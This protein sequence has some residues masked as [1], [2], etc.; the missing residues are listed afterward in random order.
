M[1]VE[2]VYTKYSAESKNKKTDLIDNSS[3]AL[4]TKIKECVL[5][6]SGKSFSF[7]GTEHKN[8]DTFLDET[9]AEELQKLEIEAFDQLIN[10][11]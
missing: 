6:S 9:I 10:K 5:T 3:N 2:E 7:F 1:Y 4:H 11:K 8:N